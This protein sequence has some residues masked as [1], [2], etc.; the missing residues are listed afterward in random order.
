MGHQSD[1]QHCGNGCHRDIHNV[2]SNEDRC[3]Q[4]VILL[5]QVQN[6]LRFV[7]SVAEKYAENN[8]K[9]TIATICPV[10][11]RSIRYLLLFANIFLSAYIISI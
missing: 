5:A 4:F 7:V 3:Q 8:I 1:E 6:F 9:I 2:V 11:E 10:M